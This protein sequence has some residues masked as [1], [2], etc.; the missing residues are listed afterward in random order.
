MFDEVDE[1]TA[2]YKVTDKGPLVKRFVSYEG[3][4]PDCY[5]KLTPAATQMIRGDAPHSARIP[6]KIPSPKV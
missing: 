5:L 6:E 3:M 4:G 1:G 2:I